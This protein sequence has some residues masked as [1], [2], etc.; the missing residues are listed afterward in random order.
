MPLYT[1]VCPE[2]HKEAGFAKIAERDN[3]RHCLCGGLFRRIIEA[4]ALR[5]EIQS[6]QS[7][8]TGEWIDSRA[9][10]REDLLRTGSMEWEPGLRQDLAKRRAERFEEALAPLEKGVEEVARAMVAS[11]DLPPI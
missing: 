2:G 7:P 8:V 5:P 3:P 11:G 4:P 1:F 10:R 9:Q 6:Y